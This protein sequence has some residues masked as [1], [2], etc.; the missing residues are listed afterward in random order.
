MAGMS[1]R[2]KGRSNPSHEDEI[3]EIVAG[4]VHDDTEWEPPVEVR[5]TGE[6]HVELSGELAARALFI[7]RAHRARTLDQ[8]LERIIRERVELE[9][10]AFASAKREM[11]SRRPA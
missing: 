11:S 2:T 6:T 5:R 8:W 10:S 1:D 9:E 4:Q 7:A 3:D